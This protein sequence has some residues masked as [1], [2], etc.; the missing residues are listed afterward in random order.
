MEAQSLSQT[1][2]LGAIGT[3]LEAEGCNES[4]PTLPQS[5]VPPPVQAESTNGNQ[6]LTDTITPQSSPDGL[7]V[8]NETAIATT[9]PA[10][11]STTTASSIAVPGGL[12]AVNGLTTSAHASI[13]NGATR[14]ARAT[15]DIG[16]LSLANGAV[17]LGGLHWDAEEQSGGD[18]HD[19]RDLLRRLADAWPACPSTSR[20]RQRCD[21]SRELNVINT[22]LSPIGFNIQWPDQSTL[23]DGTVEIS[24]LSIGIDN[25]ALGQ[26][27]IGANR[28]R[29]QPEREALVN[30]ML[31][32][33]CNLATEITVGDI[34]IGVL[35]GGGN[36]NIDLG[37]AS[38]E[39]DDLAGS[40]P[41]GPG[42]AP[43]CPSVPAP[44]LAR[45][46]AAALGRRR[47]ARDGNSGSGSARLVGRSP[48]PPRRPRRRRRAGGQPEG[49]ARTDDPN[50]RTASASDRP[51]A[52]ATPG[53]SPFPSGWASLGTAGGALH[54]GRRAAAPPPAADRQAA[55]YGVEV[56][57]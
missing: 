26:E 53:T 55:H 23:P 39:T 48:A 33:D 21:P 22:A 49:G 28:E 40:S 42:G 51:A 54:V 44:G 4:P 10:A 36:M 3:S 34:G 24:P 2:D 8:G 52:G 43:S 13:D 20:G 16:Q 1:I 17:V 9:Q 6:N 50:R 38:A 11:G 7:G 47:A 29:V 14:T 30:A 12:L 35:A 37:G 5:D 45:A 31:N 25:N 41:F 46:T 27:V 18:D 56:T 15:A 19:D 57:Q 32:A